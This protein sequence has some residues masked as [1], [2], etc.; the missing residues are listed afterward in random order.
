MPNCV[1]HIYIYIL[2]CI[3]LSSDGLVVVKLKLITSVAAKMPWHR[4]E[5]HDVKHRNATLTVIVTFTQCLVSYNVVISAC[6]KAQQ[7]EKAMSLYQEM[8]ENGVKPDSFTCT[9]LITAFAR[10][11]ARSVAIQLVL[12][13][14]GRPLSTVQEACLASMKRSIC[15]G[16]DA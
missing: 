3:Y 7:P 5:I 9:G 15:S 13:L 12:G 4:T 10:V 1:F 8:T 16:D 14:L 6:G 2:I 11:S